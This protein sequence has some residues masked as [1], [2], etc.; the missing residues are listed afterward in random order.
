MTAARFAR[1][2]S[3]SMKRAIDRGGRKPFVP[4]DDGPGRQRFQIAHEGA[5]RLRPRPFRPIHIQRQTHHETGN[6]EFVGERQ[7]LRRIGRKFAP[8]QCFERRGEAALD[9]GEREPN[10]LGAEID[11]H[12]PLRAAK[13]GQE[14]AEF[15]KIVDRH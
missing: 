11:A 1:E 3:R 6:V 8:L 15:V 12:Q 9:I 4:E 5:R 10:C 7:Q 13:A 14:V 2:T